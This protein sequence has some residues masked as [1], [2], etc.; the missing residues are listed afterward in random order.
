MP[1]RKP[2][3]TLPLDFEAVVKGLLQTPPPPAGT[4][5]SRK[6]VTLD[7][8]WTQALQMD[9]R[10]L[11][12]LRRKCGNEHDWKDLP[13]TATA[14]APPP[15]YCPRCWRAFTYVRKSEISPPAA[16]RQRYLK[17]RLEQKGA[18]KR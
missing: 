4:P 5:G 11:S 13:R 2:P 14:G 16:W 1:K 17:R 18:K 7:D 12:A 10:K 8:V 3:L 15:Y 9:Q 6:G